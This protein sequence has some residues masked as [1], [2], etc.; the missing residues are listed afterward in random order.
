M[1]DMKTTW[2]SRPKKSSAVGLTRK[3]T[4][5]I[6]WLFNWEKAI[7]CID[8]WYIDLG[9]ALILKKILYPYWKDLENNKDDCIEEIKT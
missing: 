7:M 4:Y 2:D 3:T 9:K 8:R 6:F 5:L 1:K